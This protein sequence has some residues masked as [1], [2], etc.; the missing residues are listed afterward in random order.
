[1]SVMARIKDFLYWNFFRRGLRWYLRL[2]LYRSRKAHVVAPS[3][4]NEPFGVARATVVYIN[5]DHRKDRQ[6]EF[7]GELSRL[8]IQ[9]AV[10][11]SGVP[12]QHGGTGNALSHV[13]ALST[14]EGKKSE[15]L[16]VCE[17]DAEFLVSRDELDAIVEEFARTPYLDVLCLGN[18]S[19]ERPIPVSERLAVA[20]HI[21]T[22]SCYVVRESSAGPLAI[23]AATAT[24]RLLQGAP[25]SRAAVDRVW[26]REQQ[27]LL[28]CVPR[29][30]V[31]RQRPSFSDI[32]AR[33]VAYNA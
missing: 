9:N 3:S 29:L 25:F 20:N 16:M 8:K 27:K 31:V 23:S 1:M 2:R 30:P 17:D 4:Q 11:I 26:K 5:L 21:Q 15:L 7:A 10:R 33:Q 6:K 14:L 24:R 22:T 12:T 18:A 32:E 19:L 13:I 28:F